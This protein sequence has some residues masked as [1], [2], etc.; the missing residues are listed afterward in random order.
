MSKKR[1][2]TILDIIKK[3]G[4]VTV[5]YLCDE[6]HYSTATINRDLNTLQKQKL[7]VRHYGGAEPAKRVGA[8]LVFR[9]QKMRPVKNL[10]AKEAAKLIKDGMTIFIDSS[11]TTHYI[12]R[13]ITNI[14]DLTVITNNLNLASFLSEYG[15]SC[16]CLG[17]KITAPPHMTGGVETIEQARTYNADLFFFSTCGFRADGKI[18]SGG[19]FLGN[20]MKENSK[21]TV[22]LVDHNKIDIEGP[23]MWGD[24][25]SVDCIITDYKFSDDIKEKFK[26]TEFIEVDTPVTQKN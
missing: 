10:L 24:L 6:L 17:G 22:Y 18:Y 11:T 5:K 25:S 20:A 15:V 14:K 26:D 7:I 4:Y 19:F 2:D 3:Q 13:F 16:I 12:G 9:Y 1:L 23:R 8:K 21:K